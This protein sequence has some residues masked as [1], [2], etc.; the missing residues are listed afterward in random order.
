[1][2]RQIAPHG[3]V[4]KEIVNQKVA[5]VDALDAATDHNGIVIAQEHNAE[6]GAHQPSTSQGGTTAGSNIQVNGQPQMGTD[7]HIQHTGCCPFIASGT[8]NTDTALPDDHPG[9]HHVNVAHGQTSVTNGT[10]VEDG[11][12]NE[13][14]GDDPTI[15]CLHPPSSDD[16]EHA[17]TG[18]QTEG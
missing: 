14:G 15:H 9:I 7:S 1:M 18:V 13:H 5:K 6:E 11:T 10:A 17:G 3:V 4:N 12:T 8:D 16:E 2:F